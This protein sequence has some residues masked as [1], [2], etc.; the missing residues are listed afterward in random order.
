MKPTH[1]SVLHIPQ[2]VLNET[3]K[4]LRAH[5]N[6][7]KECIVFWSGRLLSQNKGCITFCIY[8]NQQASAIGAEVNLLESAK[9]HLL[10][11]K[12]QEFLFAQ[13]HTHPGEAFH[14]F[15]DN[16]Y[17]LTDKPGFFSIVVPYY[18]ATG[19][20]NLSKCAVY[21]YKGEGA[22]RK[23]DKKEIKKRFKVVRQINE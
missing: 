2:N 1:I 14:S 20:K 21:E 9:I 10:L 3:L 11:Y 6:E 12:R 15:T 4:Y 16:Y 5:G 13:V 22:W 8:P 18:C 7:G 23:L 19:L 17:P